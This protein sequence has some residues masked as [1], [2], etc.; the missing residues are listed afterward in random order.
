MK[1]KMLH[2]NPFIV[3]E[4]EWGWARLAVWALP[5]GGA[6]QIT[7]QAPPSAPEVWKPHLTWH[8]PTPLTLPPPLA[9]TFLELENPA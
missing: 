1:L 4:G 7:V 2:E 5:Q 9:P 6:L 8:V 3:K